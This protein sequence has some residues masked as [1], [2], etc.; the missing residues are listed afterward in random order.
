MGIF[1]KLKRQK[2]IDKSKEEA[3]QA[4]AEE[5]EV[6]EK[7]AEK[8]AGADKAK[9]DKAKADKPEKKTV[10]KGAAK[11]KSAKAKAKAAKKP[12]KGALAKEGG[13]QSSQVLLK[14]VLTEKA[15]HL[16][17]MGQY[18]FLVAP[19]A[20]KVEVAAAVRDLY[21]VKPMAVKI[22]NQKGKQ[23]RF[24]RIEGQRKDRKKAIVSLKPGDAISLTD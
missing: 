24:G 1:S 2:P 8:P 21:G 16:E 22:V 9:A 14:P 10:K 19:T 17:A 23:V 7:K 4:A 5:K 20:N 18:T 13:G 11:S 12:S 15:S 6:E 3:K